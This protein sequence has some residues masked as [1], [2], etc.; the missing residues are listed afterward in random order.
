MV[1][2][3]LLCSPSSGMT[4]DGRLFN[5]SLVVELAQ[6]QLTVEWDPI[7]KSKQKYHGDKIGLICILFIS[8]ILPDV[9]VPCSGPLCIY[10]TCD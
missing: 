9:F 10:S 4:G 1:I 2:I 6:G 8:E 7:S 3:I 5:A